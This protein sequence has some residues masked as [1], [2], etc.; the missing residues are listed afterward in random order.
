MYLLVIQVP[1][2][3]VSKDVAL[4]ASD[5]ACALRLLRDSMQRRHGHIVVAAPELPTKYTWREQESVP[6]A[7]DQDG[8]RFVGLCQAHLRAMH[9]WRQ[10]R[11]VY[12]QCLEL[13]TQAEV[14]HAGMSDLFRPISQFGWLAA[15]QTNTPFVFVEDTDSAMQIRQLAA[16][17]KQV[18]TAL[19]CHLYDKVMKY[20]VTHADLSLLKGK[21]LYER[22]QPYAKNAKL[23]HNTSY[24]AH[25]VIPETQLREK[26]DRLATAKKIRC[27]YLG[28]LVA[29]KG[30]EDTL[31]FIAE[32]RQLGCDAYLDIIGGGDEKESL[33]SL[34]VALGLSEYV[35]FRGVQPYGET[36]LADLRQYDLQLQ[37]PRAEDTPRSV[38]DGLASGLPLA[39]YDV[40]YL[41]NLIHTENCGVTAPTGHVKALVRAAMALWSDRPRFVS[42]VKNSAAAGGKHAANYW[43]KKRAAWLVEALQQR[44]IS[45]KKIP[46]C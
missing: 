29:R 26:I 44:Q 16:G 19:Y 6:I 9:F 8:I 38:F 36:L 41:A 33:V 21:Q 17:R 25:W 43:Y 10:A 23:F 18:R 39:A 31:R 2:E 15:L 46:D 22:F 11:R 20:A 30:V 5:W 24:E 13:A 37:T 34:S 14:V 7:A 45:G 28:R 4:V 42:M 1:F 40:D 35:T 27:V 32:L 3:R 12:R